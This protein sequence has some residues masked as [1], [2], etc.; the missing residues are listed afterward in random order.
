MK[1]DPQR[2]IYGMMA[3]LT[4]D[5]GPEVQTP[6]GQQT[7]GLTAM[8]LSLLAQEWDRAA[9]RLVEENAA[10]AELLGRSR[11]VVRDAA[12]HE[13]ID[14]ALER[15]PG[16]N[17]RLSVLQA[18]NDVLRALLIELHA[19]VE[20]T[21]GEAAQELDKLIW[22]ELRESTRRRHFERFPV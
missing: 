11:V 19:S 6:F 13:R 5:I 4:R 9:A 15:A 1:P 7:V 2:V 17:Y 14:A 21:A 10:V 20:K 8:V 16:R 18:E 3:S 22:D 12:L